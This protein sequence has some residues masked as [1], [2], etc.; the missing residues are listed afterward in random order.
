MWYKCPCSASFSREAGAATQASA[1]AS[2]QQRRTL[3]QSKARGG[4]RAATTGRQEDFQ[5][6]NQATRQKSAKSALIIRFGQQQCWR[7]RWRREAF[8]QQ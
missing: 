3:R 2:R 8:V 5:T 1:A 6:I 4:E 7:W